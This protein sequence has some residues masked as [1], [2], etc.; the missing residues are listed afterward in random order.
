MYMKDVILNIF[1]PN[2]VK[3][4]NDHRYLL[5]VISQLQKIGKQCR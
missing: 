2:A 3:A 4:Q 1:G 5:N